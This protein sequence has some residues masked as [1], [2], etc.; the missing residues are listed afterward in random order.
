M[1]EPMVNSPGREPQILRV[2]GG[3]VV[4]PGCS[5]NRD[6]AGG[7]GQDKP[8]PRAKW[9]RL[10]QLRMARMLPL[11]EGEGSDGWVTQWSL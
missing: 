9:P 10:P 5:V 8:P 7:R 4:G 2:S 11:G 6:L 3:I 1:R